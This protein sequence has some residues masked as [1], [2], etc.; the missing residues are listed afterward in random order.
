MLSL[1][2]S[3]LPPQQFVLTLSSLL[4]TPVMSYVSDL[5][6]QVPFLL[7]FRSAATKSKLRASMNETNQQGSVTVIDSRAKAVAWI[8]VTRALCNR[9]PRFLHHTRHSNAETSHFQ[10]GSSSQEPF[11]GAGYLKTS[12]K[13]Q[14]NHNAQIPIYTYTYTQQN[15]DIKYLWNISYTHWCAF[16]IGIKSSEPYDALLL[17]AQH[18]RVALAS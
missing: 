2:C 9:P 3:C 10:P 8:S 7:D 11:C 1:I 4:N 14:E 18:L 13:S 15:D 17:F 12:S 6:R 16:D 5:F